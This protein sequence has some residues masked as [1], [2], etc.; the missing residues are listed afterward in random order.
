MLIDH[1]ALKELDDVVD[2]SVIE[3]KQCRPNKRKDG[4][5]TRDP[6]VRSLS[7]CGAQPHAF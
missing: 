4:G 1:A 5:S 7:W 2:A 3:A 6:E